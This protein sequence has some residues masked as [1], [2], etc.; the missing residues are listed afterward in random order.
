MSIATSATSLYFVDS[1]LSDLDSLLQALPSGAEVVLLQ[2]DQDGLAQML[3]ALAGREGIDA[4]HV[5]THGTPGTIQLGETS[6]SLGTLAGSA[7]ALAKIGAHL[8]AD[9]D[10]L[11]YGCS[12]AAS[13]EGKA[14]VSQLAELT[15]A[16]V[17]ASEDLTGA[18]DRGG[19]WA[20]EVSSGSVEAEVVAAP[21]MDD[22]LASGIMKNKYVKF[23]YSDNGTL[24]YGGSSKPGIQYDK[25]GTYNFL[26][27]ADFLTPGS[28]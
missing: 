7:D 21:A 28:P 1:S 18:A 16:D 26:D 24:G 9:A 19:D 14:L 22:V 13:D 3:D 11:F 17:A 4:L 10:I 5:L 8:S 12:V 2:P 20:L 15:G 25:D 23:G 27:T 6:L